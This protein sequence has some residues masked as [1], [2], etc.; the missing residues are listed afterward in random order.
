MAQ[1]QDE[2]VRRKQYEERAVKA[3]RELSD[4]TVDL[5]HALESLNR[6]EE[7]A[8]SAQKKVGGLCVG[9]LLLHFTVDS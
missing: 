4:K 1:L 3:E 2:V 7:T 6:A 9:L 8:A 5:Q